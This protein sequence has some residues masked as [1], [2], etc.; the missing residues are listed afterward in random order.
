M[1]RERRNEGRHAKTF[2]GIKNFFEVLLNFKAPF[3][4]AHGINYACRQRINYTLQNAIQDRS[5]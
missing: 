2:V 3:K 4:L 1:W 5:S